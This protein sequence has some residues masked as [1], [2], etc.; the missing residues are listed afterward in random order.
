MLD[1]LGGA[2]LSSSVRRRMSRITKITLAVAGLWFLVFAAFAAHPS[3]V[4]QLFSMLLTLGLLVFG[5]IC[6]VR[7]FT[8]WQRERWRTLVPVGVSVLVVVFAPV[9]GAAIRHF[10]FQRALPNY[11]ALIKQMEAGSVPVSSEL[12]RISQAEGSLAY[13]VLAQRGT[14][15]VLTV[16]FLTG[17]GF[18][19]KHSGYLYCSSD[20]IERGSLADS[21]WP[22]RRAVKP[23]WY[24]ISD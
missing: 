2:S 15:G 10:T 8:H 4:T 16:E 18:P 11:E 23:L 9:V 1:A 19:V 21:R 17:G 5:F 12:R 7:V 14:N 3:P 6:S 24:R 20:V 22:R 13:T